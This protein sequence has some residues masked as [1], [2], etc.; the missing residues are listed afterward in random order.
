VSYR[1]AS[2]RYAPRRYASY[3][4][5]SVYIGTRVYI[6]ASMYTCLLVYVYICVH[7][8]LH[9]ASLYIGIHRYPLVHVGIPRYTP[10]GLHRD[11][12]GRIC[13]MSKFPAVY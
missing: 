6:D 2:Y 12:L 5:A 3:R 4:Y 1:Y 7:V 10:V 9:L 13:A 8:Y 11:L